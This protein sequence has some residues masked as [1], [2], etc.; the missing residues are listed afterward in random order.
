[1]IGAYA[2]AV[3]IRHPQPGSAEQAMSVSSVPIINAGDGGGEHPTQALLDTFTIHNELGKLEGLK[4]ALIGD[5]KNGRTIHSLLFLLGLY[6]GVELILVAPEQ[7]QLPE[8][9]KAYLDQNNI[10]YK[11]ASSLEEIDDS[12]DVLYVT[13]VQKER[14]DDPAEYE[15]LKDVF[16]VD[17]QVLGRL[18][19]EAIIMHPLPRVNEIATEV[20]DDPRAAYFRQAENGL[21]ARMALLAHILG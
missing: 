8:K 9:Y 19:K 3:V 21:Y 7:L 20:D 1:V 14:F 4:V 11:E 16:I 13:R 5:L 2:D 10:I 18:K 12:F 6:S 17:K 15:K